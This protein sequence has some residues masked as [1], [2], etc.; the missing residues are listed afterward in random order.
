MHRWPTLST[1]ASHR[2]EASP[3]LD[4]KSTLAFWSPICPIYPSIQP[5]IQLWSCP[6]VHSTILL[7]ISLAGGWQWA[8][9]IQ[10]R[11]S[12]QITHFVLTFCSAIR[13]FINST[14]VVTSSPFP[15]PDSSQSSRNLLTSPFSFTPFY[16]LF[17]CL[18]LA[19]GLTKFRLPFK[20]NRLFVFHLS[21]ELP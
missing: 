13:N 19:Q 9:S 12:I 17:L 20:I 14:K 2:H 10:M 1:F 16:L 15:T 18:G 6:A 21:S 7:S 5:S 8:W 4:R 3:C 11:T